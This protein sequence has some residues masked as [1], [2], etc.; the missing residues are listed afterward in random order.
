MKRNLY[1]ADHEDF[2]R[3]VA[4]FLD[5]EVAPHFDEWEKNKIVDRSMWKAAADAGVRRELAERLSTETTG[6]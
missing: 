5:K 3:T 4:A 6:G 1:T 2:R